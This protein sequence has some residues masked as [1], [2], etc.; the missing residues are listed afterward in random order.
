MTASSQIIANHPYHIKLVVADRGD[1][2]FDSA[3]FIQAGSFTSGPPECNDKI[4]LVAFIDTNSNGVKDTGESNFSYGSFVYQ[5]NN[6]GDTYNVSSPFGE[7]TLY[8]SNS[9]NTYDFSY[10]INA[11]YAAYYSAGTTNYNDINI[12]VGSGTQTFYFPITVTQGYNDVS[13][14]IIPIG[15]PRPGFNYTLIK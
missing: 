2:A 15:Q 4:K 9:S 1:N 12:P 8:D 13:I 7:H 3:V 14:T 11:E 5:Q 6:V 10:G